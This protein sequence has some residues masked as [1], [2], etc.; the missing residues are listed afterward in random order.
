[1]TTRRSGRR[2]GTRRRRVAAAALVGAAGLAS[3][4]L[5][6]IAVRGETVYTMAGEPIADGLVVAEQGRIRYVGP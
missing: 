3:A 2:G 6:Q 5:A 4:A 1:M